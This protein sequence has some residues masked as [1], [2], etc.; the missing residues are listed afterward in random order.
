MPKVKLDITVS[1]DGYI[2]GP[3]QSADNPLGE[4]AG[5][6]HNWVLRT[7][8]WREAHGREGGDNTGDA[9]LDDA[10]AKRMGENVGAEIMGRGKFGGG[11]GPW[12]EKE[13]WNGW[14]GE[15]PPF[16]MPVFVLTHHEREP[17]TLGDTTFNFVSDGAEAAL[18]RARAAAGE[19]DILIGGGAES[20]NE[21]LAAGHVDEIQLHVAP[22]LL[23][24]GELLFAELGANLPKLELVASEGSE[25]AS[26]VRYRVVG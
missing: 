1:L 2:A 3:N 14:W 16:R 10:Y 12:N 20:A 24:G 8:A 7:T 23:G 13:P 26:H 17:L 22:L 21:Y 19:Q 6:L 9:A 15:D 4:G 18:E 5:D 11:P 25:L